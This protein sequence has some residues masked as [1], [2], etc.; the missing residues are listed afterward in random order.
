[1]NIIIRETDF[2]GVH[3]CRVSVCVPI[4]SGKKKIMTTGAFL[5]YLLREKGRWG[6]NHYYHYTSYHHIHSLSCWRRIVYMK[7]VF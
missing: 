2:L 4:L 6:D 7:I 1:M 3:Q 5:A